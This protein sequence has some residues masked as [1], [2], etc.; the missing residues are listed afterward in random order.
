MSSTSEI[1]PH[2]GHSPRDRR[3]RWSFS[4]VYEILFT[5]ADLVSTTLFALLSVFGPI[6]PVMFVYFI[7]RNWYDDLPTDEDNKK[8]YPWSKD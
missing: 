4:G 1:L 5:K 3:I 8:V 7:A 6:L 2:C